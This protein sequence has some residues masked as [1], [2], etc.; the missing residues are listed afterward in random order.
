M[1]KP[2]DDDKY[3]WTN[4]HVRNRDNK[5]DE[6]IK[7]NY[8]TPGHPTAFSSAKTVYEYYNGIYPL[9]R[10]KNILK[11]IESYSL[12]KEFHKGSRNVSYA[13][14]KRYQ[15][16]I[17]LC[18]MMDY[19]EENDGVKYLLTVIDC[20]TRF[21]F[22]R[23]L[24][25]KNS[26]SVLR[27]FQNIIDKLDIKP[28]TVVCDRGNEFVNKNFINYCK[29]NGI[30][31]IQP[32]SN[33]HAAY[34]ERFNRTIQNLIFKFMTE[35]NTNRYVDHLED[36]LHTYN[37]RFHR[38]INM[39]PIEAENNSDAALHI[40]NLIS[41]RESK[42]Q[43]KEPNLKVGDLVRIFKQ[44][45]KFTRGYQP[46][47]QVELFRIRGIS[48]NKKI[49]LYYLSNYE[50]SKDIIE[51]GFYEH[52]LIPVEIDTFRIE[53]VL[54]KRTYKGQKQI[55]VKWLGYNNKY[56][57]WIPESNVSDDYRKQ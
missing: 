31:L 44:K 34:V 57:Q 21:A 39:S 32:K 24:T 1:F 14:Y 30:K 53:K 33:V 26:N 35:N 43:K 55:Y 47:S 54:K 10:I 4:V 23:T 11:S 19:A 41:L 49:P 29:Q 17:D 6:E 9:K 18:F 27:A 28:L 22:I 36:I 46:Q 3:L 50:D 45:E 8:K 51:G 25:D 52:E 15:F 38:M 2:Y 56:N 5:A 13:R 40:N 48:S 37:S 16:Q 7:Q 42:I 12:H 20:F